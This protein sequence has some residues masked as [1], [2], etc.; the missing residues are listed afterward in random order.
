MSKETL[1]AA[2]T[3]IKLH[4]Q[5]P[6][7]ILVEDTLA[8]S[9]NALILDVSHMQDWTRNSRILSLV[10]SLISNVIGVVIPT[11]ACGA[12]L[13]ILIFECIIYLH[14]STFE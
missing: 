12:A 5:H 11:I 14:S 10:N 3:L 4:V 6:E 2:E 13:N 9:T 1:S 7:I 8:K